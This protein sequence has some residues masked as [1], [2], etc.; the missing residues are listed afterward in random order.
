M[1][2][3]FNI[4]LFFKLPGDCNISFQH[5]LQSNP[6]PEEI[7]NSTFN[8]SQTIVWGKEDADSRI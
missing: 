3:A 2:K 7:R 5:I 8:Q 1:F 4:L 6:N